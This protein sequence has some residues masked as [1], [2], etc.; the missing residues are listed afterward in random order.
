MVADIQTHVG[1]IWAVTIS[2]TV[3]LL[4]NALLGNEEVM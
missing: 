1:E 2:A 3:A 4:G